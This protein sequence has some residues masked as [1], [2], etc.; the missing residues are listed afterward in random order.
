MPHTF[1]DGNCGAPYPGGYFTIECWNDDCGI[2]VTLSEKRRTDLK[3]MTHA[4]AEIA[5]WPEIHAIWNRRA[6]ACAVSS[7]DGEANESKL[8]S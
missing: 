4:E 3:G 2:Q 1:V 6:N 8:K 7:G 5:I